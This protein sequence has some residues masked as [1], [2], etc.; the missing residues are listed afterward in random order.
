[1]SSLYGAQDTSL[2]SAGFAASASS[3]AP[4]GAVRPSGPAAR[5]HKE[6]SLLNV[7]RV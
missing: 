2:T 5:R 3:H 4:A 7:T 6:T 1:M